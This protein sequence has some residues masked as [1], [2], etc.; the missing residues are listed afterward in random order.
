[1]SGGVEEAVGVRGPALNAAVG[2]PL[3]EHIL[4]RP[5]AERYWRALKEV[6]DPELPISVVDMGLIYDIEE[7][8]SER[9]SPAAGGGVAAG[10]GIALAVTMTFTAT[11]CPCMELMLMD[12]RD[13]LLEE[14]GVGEVEIDIVW[15]PPWTRA[16]ITDEGRATLRTYGVAS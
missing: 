3:L 15:D 16:M 4:V 1:V 8:P 13:R 14:E 11:A 7:R 5:G 10:G 12:I 6:L 9:G 2:A